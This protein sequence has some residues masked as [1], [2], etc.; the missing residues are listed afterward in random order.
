MAS[1]VKTSKIFINKQGIAALATN[2]LTQQSD[3]YTCKFHKRDIHFFKFV[4]RA[5]HIVVCRVVE[6]KSSTKPHAFLYLIM[7]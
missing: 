6:N 3:L 1:A 5:L 7:Q 4:K 2:L